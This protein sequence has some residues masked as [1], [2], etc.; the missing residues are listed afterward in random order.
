[1][2]P[3]Q[4]PDLIIPTFYVPSFHG[5]IRLSSTTTK[6]CS[7]TTEKVTEQ[8]KAA[9]RS[10]RTQALK[11]GW[12]DKE[13]DFDRLFDGGVLELHADIKKVSRA[14]AKALKP[15][16]RIVS[17]VKFA[18]GKMEEIVEAKT[19]E[20]AV[21][22]ANSAPAVDGETKRVKPR[23]VAATAVAAPVIGC[24]APDFEKAEIKARAVLAAFLT[25][26][27][28]DDFKKFNRF[29]SVGAV[30]GHRY[31]ITSRL[32]R[33]ELARKYSRTLY[34][35]EE[36]MPICT[37]DWL[38]PAAEEMLSMHVLLSLPGWERY[39]RST[40]HDLEPESFNPYEGLPF[41]VV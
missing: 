21:T 35:L 28:I 37:H 1:M 14:I 27:Q 2:Q 23:A 10:L 24:P 18:D 5:D 16:R 25:T 40:E 36:E 19:F 34:D 11:K 41:E 38:I 22:R 29:I 6:S 7:V 33:D 12:L 8:E 4:H 13:G 15:D 30:T 3:N 31:M 9:L 32:A 39:L 26:D 17:A 20:T